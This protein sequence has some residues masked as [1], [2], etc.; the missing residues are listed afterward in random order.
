MQVHNINGTS[1]NE[2][3]CG[4]WKNHWIKYNENVQ[5]WPVFWPLQRF[6]KNGHNERVV[7]V[8]GRA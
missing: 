5:E 7:S 4:S 3:V 6:V 2:C 8:S 1:D